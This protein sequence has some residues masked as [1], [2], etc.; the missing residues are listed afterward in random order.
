[1]IYDQIAKM[2]L[3]PSLEIAEVINSLLRELQSR[4]DYI[5]DYENCEMFWI[6]W[7]ITRQKISTRKA[8]G[9]DRIICIVSFKKFAVDREVKYAKGWEVPFDCQA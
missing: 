8:V 4:R 6:M 5:L 1:M 2:K 3:L 7:S 9:M